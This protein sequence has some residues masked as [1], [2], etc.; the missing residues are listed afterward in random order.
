ML[1][2]THFSNCKTLEDVDSRLSKALD[3]CGYARK[4]YFFVPNGFALVTQLERIDEDGTSKPERERWADEIPPTRFTI[5]AYIYRL[6]HAVPGYYRTI[7]FLVSDEIHS[8]SKEKA[9]KDQVETWLNAGTNVLPPD[10]RKLP[11]N[12]NYSYE[13]LIYEFKKNETESEAKVLV[14]SNLS[15]RT[16]VTKSR[17]LANL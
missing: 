12:T 8:F 5:S 3:N 6:F 15:G 13:V 1:P 11:I 4:S 9:N 2:K 10:T 14:P 7:V 16:H 17:I